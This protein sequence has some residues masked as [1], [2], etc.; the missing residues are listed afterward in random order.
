MSAIPENN[1]EFRIFGLRRS[2]NH[3]IIAWITSSMPDN[4]VYFFNDITANYDNSFKSLLTS[5]NDQL[6]GTIANKLIRRPRGNENK[7]CIIQS[8]EDNELSIIADINKQIK[9]GQIGKSKKIFNILIMR[10]LPNLLASRYQLY[11]SGNKYVEITD[12]IIRLYREYLNEFISPKLL[13]GDGQ[14]FVPL[15]Y[16]KW[17]SD[18]KYRQ[19]IAQKLSID[20]TKA[21][22]KAKM[23]YGGGSSFEHMN[24][25]SSSLNSSTNSSLN[26]TNEFNSRYKLFTD[27]EKYKKIIEQNKK[28][29]DLSTKLLL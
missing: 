6:A 5:Y 7:H 13:N 3:A 14:I 26:S 25:G 1:Y 24:K 21:D 16:S 15:N 28:L 11:K 17:N 23:Y 29:I 27:D 19:D 2:G 8:Y 18:A 4:S 10:D 9:T 20:I 12:G 22:S